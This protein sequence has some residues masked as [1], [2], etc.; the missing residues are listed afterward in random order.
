[1]NLEESKWLLMNNLFPLED[2]LASTFE[3]LPSAYHC[4]HLHWRDSTRVALQ[5]L[6]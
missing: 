2:W 6:R 4:D 1:M 3:G 5:Q